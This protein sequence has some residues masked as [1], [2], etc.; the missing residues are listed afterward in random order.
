MPHAVGIAVHDQECVLPACD[1]EIRGVVTRTRG[2]RKE[3][4]VGLFLFE[5]LDAPRAPKR[6]NF[7]FRKFHQVV[8]SEASLQITAA[9]SSKVLSKHPLLSAVERKQN[10]ERRFTNRRPK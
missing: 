2:L 10:K 8:Q 3:V 1:H 4:G 9:K 7:S 5:I 6:F